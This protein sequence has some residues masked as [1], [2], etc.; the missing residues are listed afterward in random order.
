M[1]ITNEYQALTPETEPVL[2]AFE[3]CFLEQVKLHPEFGIREIQYLAFAAISGV[4]ATECLRFAVRRKLWLS[5][6]RGFWNLPYV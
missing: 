4:G 1:P 3:K 6:P 2:E 5:L